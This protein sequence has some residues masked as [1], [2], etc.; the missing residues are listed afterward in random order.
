IFSRVGGLWASRGLLLIYIIFFT[1]ALTSF[2]RAAIL[3]LLVGLL[4]F[5]FDNIFKKEIKRRYFFAIIILSA[6]ISL[7]F[8]WQYR[9]LVWS[10]V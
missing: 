2:S 3:A 4:V 6:V 1:A 9:E 10:R 7:L 8:F 5:V